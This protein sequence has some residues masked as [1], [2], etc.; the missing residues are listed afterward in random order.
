MKSHG[1]AALPDLR[2]VTWRRSTR[3]SGGGSGQC[4]ESGLS[5]ATILVRDSKDCQGDTYPV[6]AVDAATWRGFV[7]GLK[8]TA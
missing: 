6:L 5:E 3:S 4:V 8:S 1:T 7:N 2:H